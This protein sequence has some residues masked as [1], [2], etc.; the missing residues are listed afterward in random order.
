MLGTWLI[1]L[2]LGTAI[3]VAIAKTSLPGRQFLERLFVAMLFVPLFVQ[4]TAWQAAVGQGGWLVPEGVN[5][6]VGWGGAIWV[7]GVAA[8]P[9]VVLFVGVGLRHVPRELEEEA[10]QDTSGPRVLWSVSLRHSVASVFAA[11][12]WIA[13]ICAGEIAVTDVFRIRT[14]AEE[15]YT[16]ANLGSSARRSGFHRFGTAS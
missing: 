14:F 13:V 8:V 3:A 6:L 15:V 12:M 11:A 16:T 1:S 5:L 4:A 7:H 10:L 9:W 2:P